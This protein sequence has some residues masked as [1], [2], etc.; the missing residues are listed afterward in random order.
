MKGE[1]GVWGIC[2]KHRESLKK[3]GQKSRMSLGLR[4]PNL[5]KRSGKSQ[6]NI[7]DDMKTNY[8]E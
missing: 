7:I 5:V 6:R 2:K 3:E 1:R 8:D 4:D